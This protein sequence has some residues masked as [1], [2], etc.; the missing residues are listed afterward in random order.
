MLCWG[1]WPV[2][3]IPFRDCSRDTEVA[4]L[5]GGETGWLEG[6]RLATVHEE[7]MSLLVPQLNGRVVER[8]Q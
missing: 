7:G 2:R 8:V 5:D 6:L 3:R 1:C 4:L